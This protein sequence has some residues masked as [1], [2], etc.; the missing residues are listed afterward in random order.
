M[1]KA[2]TQIKS[3]RSLGLSATITFSKLFLAKILPCFS[4]AFSLLHIPEWGPTHDLIRR[5]FAKALSYTCGWILPTGV[6]THPGVWSMIF[7]FPAV[8]SFLRQEKLLM[9]ARLWVGDFKAGRIFRGL[10]RKG[11]GSFERDVDKALNEWFLESSWNSLD[12]G[13]VFKF[14]KKVKRIAKKQWPHDLAKNCQLTWLYHNHRCYSGNMPVFADWTWP[15]SDSGK[16]FERHFFM[17]LTGLHPAGG[18]RAI[19]GHSPCNTDTPDSVYRHHFFECVGFESN[20]IFFRKCAR[21]LYNESLTVGA[22]L[23]PVSLLDTVLIKPCPMWVGLMDPGLFLPGI[24][25]RYIHELHRIV[26]IAG[27]FSWGRFYELP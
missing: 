18:N 11:G 5:V 21:R 23:I 7:G 19:C 26:T 22:S 1:K 17:L 12:K 27:I 25:L 24:K 20:R 6:K 9:A 13:N 4:Y 10:F 2:V 3:W 15:Q 14:K 16:K 8:S